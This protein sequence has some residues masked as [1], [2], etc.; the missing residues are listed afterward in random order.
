MNALEA[1]GK[2]RSVRKY[3]GEPIP[4]KDLEK[5]VDAGRLAATGSNQQPWDF[6]VVTDRAMVARLKVAAEWMEKA[7]AIIAVVMDPSSRWWIE[8]GSA[9]VENM[10]IASTALGYGSCW[11]EGYT[12]P[13]EEEFKKLLDVPKEKRL[14]TLVPIGVPAEEPTREKRSLQE[15]LH[16]ERY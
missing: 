14:L 3:T 7:A 11:L 12:L 5:I 8:D 6:V 2:R 15:V 16:W 10:L 9:A 13:H 1:I 4:G